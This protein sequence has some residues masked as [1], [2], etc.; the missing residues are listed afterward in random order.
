MAQ[1]GSSSARGSAAKPRL[2]CSVAADLAELLPS[3]AAISECLAEEGQESLDLLQIS[4]TS[5]EQMQMQLKA[6][7]SRMQSFRTLWMY[8]TVLGLTPVPM[9]YNWETA[10]QVSFSGSPQGARA[11][12]W[13]R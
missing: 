5:F 6:S 2:Q 10:P 9:P 8:C 3:I 12:T 13:I 1:A 11:H 4:R 7:A